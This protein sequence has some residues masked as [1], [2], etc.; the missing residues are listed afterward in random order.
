MKG[1][2][3]LTFARRRPRFLRGLRRAV[4][5]AGRSHHARS[6]AHLLF[7]PAGLDDLVHRVCDRLRLQHRLAHDAAAEMGLARRCGAR[8][9]GVASCTIGL[10]TGPF[11]ARPVWGIWWT[12][13]AR[14][15]TTFILWLLYIS[16]LAAARAARRS[17]TS[18]LRFRQS[19]VFSRFS[20]CRLSMFPTASGGRS[21]RSP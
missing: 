10:I 18:A 4:H 19:S 21:T 7:P 6:P 13:D 15:T 8:K 9:S 20:M 11:G 16:Y 12:W 1:R 3:A 2:I 17:A 5:C 14:L